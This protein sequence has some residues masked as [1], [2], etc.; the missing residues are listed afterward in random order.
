MICVKCEKNYEDSY[1]LEQ[2]IESYNVWVIKKE[3]ATGK[4]YPVDMS[5]AV[6][7]SCL[8]ERRMQHAKRFLVVWFIIS[9]IFFLGACAVVLLL[10]RGDG[11]LNTLLTSPAILMPLTPL[12]MTPLGF[13]IRYRHPRIPH[14]LIAEAKIGK[15]AKTWEQSGYLYMVLNNKPTGIVEHIGFLG[16]SEIKYDGDR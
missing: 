2:Q 8:K 14:W 7:N 5:A 15:G 3:K 4:L 12:L 1:F 6:C 13:W 10:S 11:S 9:V 16:G